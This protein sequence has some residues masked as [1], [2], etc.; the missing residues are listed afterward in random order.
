M[1]RLQTVYCGHDATFVISHEQR[2]RPSGV[3]ASPPIL[4]CLP[5]ELARYRWAVF[6]SVYVDVKRSDKYN[7]WCYSLCTP[8]YLIKRESFRHKSRSQALWLPN[9]KRQFSLSTKILYMVLG[10]GAV[11]KSREHKLCN[12]RVGGEL[13]CHCP[14]TL[15][16]TCISAWR[17][18]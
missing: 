10:K 12:C 2:L 11:I 1:R 13:H 4:M 7:I 3:C 16:H 14:L 18:W 9:L 5:L 17:S 6:K 15:S 8:V